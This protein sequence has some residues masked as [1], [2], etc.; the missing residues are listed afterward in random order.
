MHYFRTIS[1][2]LA[3]SASIVSMASAQTAAQADRA[4]DSLP[5]DIVVTAQK[6]EQSMNSVGLSLQAL[7]GADLQKRRIDSAADLVKA[8]PGFTFTPSPYATP[9]YTLRGVGLY[10]SGLA[11]APSVSVY[12]DEVPLA[13]PI[14]TLGGTLDLERVEVLKGPQ[15]TLFGQSSTGGAVNYIAAKPTSTFRYGANGSLN[16]FGQVD[17]EGFVSGPISP[18]LG[19]RLAVKT[20]QGGAWQKSTSRDDKLGDA[21]FLTGRLLLDWA[22][23]DTLKFSFNANGFIDK[24]DPLAP[25]LIKVAP[26]NPALIAP[27]FDQSKPARRP[28]DADWPEGYPDRDN[29]FYQ[30]ALRGDLNL[31]DSA[32]LTSITSYQK[33]KADEQLPFSG[34]PFPYQNILH[35]GFVKSFN[36]ELRLSGDAGPLNWIVGASYEHVKS[37]DHIRYDQRIVSNRVIIPGLPAYQDAHASIA[38]KNETYAFF[39]NLDYRLTDRLS[40]RAGLRYTHNK[41]TGVGCT[42]DDLPSN[43]LGFLFEAIQASIKGSAVPIGPGDCVTLDDNVNPGPVPLRL[44]EGNVSWRLGL[45]YKLDNGT[46][47]Y[48]TVSRG[49]KQGILPNVAAVQSAQYDPAVRERLDAYEVGVKAPIAGRALQVNASAFYYDYKDKQIRGTVLNAF[50]KLEREINV[51]KSRVFGLE[52]EVQMRP[53]RGL[54]ASVGATYLDTKITSSISTIP[55]TSETYNSDGVQIDAKGA[56]I[57]FAPKYTVVGDAEYDWAIGGDTQALVGGGLVYHSADNGSL[58]TKAVPATEFRIKPYTVIDLRAGLQAADGRWR[59]TVWVSNV[60]NV[61]RWNTVFRTI[62]DYFRYQDRPRT[63]GV[64]ISY[65]P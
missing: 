19:A 47:V 38:Q 24:G 27:G 50:G 65:R 45:D 21:R 49:F 26:T 61:L 44:S 5:G 13:Y 16:Q 10:D 22:P 58:A 34:T 40:A 56:R 28:R 41:T 36:Q 8:V 54:N 17:L 15:G 33:A 57:P 6:R 63:V 52:A 20:Q 51:P 37:D 39:G 30:V 62:D 31:S 48:A 14:M 9:V 2:F 60:F 55:G 3:T 7:S 23:S 59:G 1:L 25:S 42:F 4:T 29:S 32:K 46:L 12:M 11:V 18:T 53:I 35:F 43:E 64:S